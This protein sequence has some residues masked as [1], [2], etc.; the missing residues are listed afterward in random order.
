MRKI[1]F[2]MFLLFL[3]MANEAKAQDTSPWGVSA[4][5]LRTEE[6]NNIDGSFNAVRSAGIKWLRE[7]FKF[8]DIYIESGRF[9]FS[10]YD[11]LL[12]KAKKNDIHILPILE[13]YDNELLPKHKHLTPLYK[14]LEVWREYV[15]A[16]VQR[17]HESIKYWEIWNEPDGGFWKPAPN[18]EQYVSMLKI[19]YEEIKKIDPSCQV[20]VGGLCLWNTDFIKSMYHAGAKGHFDLIAVHPYNHG[21]DINKTAAREMKETVALVKKEEGKAIPFWITEAGGTSFV[22]ELIAQQPDFMRQAISYALDKI[23]VEDEEITIG[24]ALSPRHTFVDEVNTTRT[25]LP[26]VNIKP[27][28]FDK[29]E[30]LDPKECQV[31]IGAE[32]LKVDL[33]LM[34]PLHEYV[35]KG[36]LLL[37]VNKVPFYSVFY[38][39]QNNTW[40]LADSVSYTYPLLR[41]NFEAHWTK[42]GLPVSTYNVA[43]SDD[44]GSFGL[45]KI[46]KVYMDRFLDGKNLED[47]G[48]FYPIINALGADGES[49][50]AGMGVYTYTDWKGG[51]LLSTISVETGYTESEQ[52]NLLQ[53]MYLSYL[54][55]GV[56]KIFWYDLHNDGV[57]IGERE[58]NFGLLNHNFTPK[59]AYYAYMHMTKMLGEKPHFVEKLEGKDASVWALVFQKEENKEKVLACW[60]IDDQAKL[61]ISSDNQAKVTLNLT[62]QEVQFY[63]LPTDYKIKF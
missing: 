23:G 36:G 45:P 29:L 26:N 30:N 50:G 17:Y 53:R 21:L 18:A 33:P 35:K 61:E 4:H 40:Q 24:L 9:N 16:T 28:P 39:D 8:S 62:A 14:H 46:K 58:H 3:L 10:K 48:T 32:G 27:I 12:V 49:I 13:A 25:W 11:S 44:A 1:T 34:K 60:S 47:K 63:V 52:A 55:A 42:P 54:S 2:W 7:D 6:W 31:L 15:R 41:M 59:K 5:P 57:M 38:Q 56:E 19:A 43:T 37:G 51:V 20:M 22:G